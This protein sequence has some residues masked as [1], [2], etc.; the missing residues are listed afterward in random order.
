MNPASADLD[1]FVLESLRCCKDIFGCG[2][3]WHRLGVRSIAGVLKNST[4][5]RQPRRTAL[6]KAQHIAICE[7]FQKPCNAG[8]RSEALFFYDGGEPLDP[9]QDFRRIVEGEAEP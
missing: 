6:W 1:A 2:R 5:G 8:S 3:L 9:F 7:H 4:S